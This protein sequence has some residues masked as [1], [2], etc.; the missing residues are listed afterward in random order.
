MTVILPQK[1][2]PQIGV[3]NVSKGGRHKTLYLLHGFSDN[4]MAWLR[5]TSVERYAAEF[6]LA[7]VMPNGY[8]SFYSNMEHGGD[9][10]TFLSEEL[11]AVAR[12]LFPL[13][14]EKEDNFVAGVSMGGY[15]AFKWAL[16]KPGMF[17][18]AGS[19]S[20]ELDMAVRTRDYEAGSPVGRAV[21]A[22]YGN[23]TVAG[24]DD[25]LLALLGRQP[26]GINL[27][28]LYQYCGTGDFLYA[29]NITFRNACQNHGRELHYIEESGDHTWPYWDRA[30]EN[31]LKWL[32]GKSLL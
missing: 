3:T 5:Y 18:S 30:V 27:P 22:I 23:R 10:W 21:Q 8:T 25:D 24:S 20:G 9:Y 26:T 29:H 6:G 17:T 19:F 7:I 11:P 31:Y 13:S 12:S 32:A 16:R 1:T 28:L 2:S 4:H 14:C 15:G